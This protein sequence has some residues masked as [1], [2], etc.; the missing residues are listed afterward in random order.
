[1]IESHGPADEREFSLDELVEAAASLL[2]GS[3]AEPRDGRVSARPDARAVRYYQ[4]LGI[5]AAPLGY[6]GRRAVYGRLH[7]LQLVAVKRLQSLGLSLSQVQRALASKGAA[8]LEAALSPEA[9]APAE[10]PSHADLVPAAR[11][12][13]DSAPGPLGLVAAKLAPGIT[14]IVDTAVVEDAERLLSLLGRALKAPE[15]GD[16]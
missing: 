6:E 10:P 15:G 13:L 3:V 14:V 9:V 7:L 12:G 11:G 5:V 2:A 16:P 4:Q 8:E 1:M